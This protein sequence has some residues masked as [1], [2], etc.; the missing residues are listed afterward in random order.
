MRV[1]GVSKGFQARYMELQLYSKE[2]QG[3]QGISGTFQG[4][5]EGLESVP[6]VFKGFLSTV[7][8]RSPYSYILN[9]Y[10]GS[11]AL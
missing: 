4:V 2:F 5:A 1:S 7:L 3:F 10:Y 11:V 6:G 9:S 8:S